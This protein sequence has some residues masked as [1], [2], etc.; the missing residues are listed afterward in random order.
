MAA[1]QLWKQ[2][3]AWEEEGRSFALVTVVHS[4]GSTPRRPGAKM[5]VLE[6]G[7][8]QGTIG[9]GALEHKAIES[10]QEVIKSGRPQLFEHQLTQ[11]L[12]MCCGGQTTLFIEPFLPRPRL[13]IFGAGHV[14]RALCGFAA[15]S[16][17]RVTVVDE[18]EELLKPELLAEAEALLDDHRHPELPYG[19][20]T[21]VMVTTHDHALDQRLVEYTL[22]HNY[23]WLGLIGSRRKAELTK[24]RLLTKGFGPEQVGAVRCP[25]GLAIGAQ[26]PEEIAIS[27]LAELIAVKRHQ[28]VQVDSLQAETKLKLSS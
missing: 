5:L 3:A 6:G 26:T 1:P 24:K 12:G 13:V 9:G 28:A 21:F 15:A 19:K 14:G 27:I 11:E 2:I 16:G 8:S 7:Q 20:N 23:R 17:F 18:R 10:A 22:K 4:K 25:V